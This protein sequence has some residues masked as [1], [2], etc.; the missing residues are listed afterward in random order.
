M[1][2][3]RLWREAGFTPK[4]AQTDAIMHIDGSLS[5]PAGPGSGK[6]RVLLWRTLNIV[7][8]GVP[9]ERIFLSTFTEK[10][11]DKRKEALQA[12]LGLA[13]NATGQPYDIAQMDVGT[14]HSLFQR[15]SQTGA[16]PMN[17]SVGDH[18]LSWMTWSS[19]RICTG[20]VAKA[21]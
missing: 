20:A 16:F 14:E 8:H 15:L 19:A 7:F 6:T 9:P 3:D 1:T 21:G 11:A 13:G 4:A 17:V 18:R 2:I 12:L 10:A 5:L